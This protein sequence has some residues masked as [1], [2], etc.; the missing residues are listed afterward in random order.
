MRA[1]CKDRRSYYHY[2]SKPGDTGSMS[3][4]G[5]LVG[6]ATGV[7]LLA[8]LA[9]AASAV[10]YLKHFTWPAWAGVS[11]AAAAAVMTGLGKKILDVVFEWPLA[12]FSSFLSRGRLIRKVPGY[13]AKVIESTHRIMLNIHPA[14]PLSANAPAGLS[15]EF[16]LYVERDID[17]GLRAW[18]KGRSSRSCLIV[19]V[20]PAASGKTRL[21][22]EALKKELPDWQLLIPTSQQINALV[23][24]NANLARSILWLD[25]LQTFFE[26]DPLRA[27]TVEALLTGHHGPVVLAGTIRSGERARLLGKIATGDREMSMNANTILR[28]PARWSGQ[29]EGTERAVQFDIPGQLSQAEQVRAS[30]LSPMDPRLEVALHAAR[31]GD[32]TATLACEA[33]LVDRWRGEGD[34][35]GQ[36]VMTAAVVARLCGHPEPIGE[37]VLAAV[38]ISYLSDMEDAPEVSNRG[39]RG[40]QWLCLFSGKGAHRLPVGALPGRPSCAP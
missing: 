36:A 22:I 25:E 27:A 19:L 28:M 33:E 13:R 18:I 37:G 6:A 23:A 4:R 26:G 34:R 35:N 30:V 39:T 2:R 38:A 10:L 32:F 40:M 14:I 5:S 8:V 11:L 21:L 9:V 15:D 12:T 7:V 31:D 1:A 20:G 16:P 29:V 3:G 17:A 24:A